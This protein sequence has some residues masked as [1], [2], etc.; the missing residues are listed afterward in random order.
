MLRGFILEQCEEEREAAALLSK[1]TMIGNDSA[2]IYM[3][4]SEL[5][6]R[7]YKPFELKM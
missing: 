4:N 7:T 5:K 6:A 3:L 1:A 2:G